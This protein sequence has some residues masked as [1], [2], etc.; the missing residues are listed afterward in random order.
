L[1][2]LWGQVKGSAHFIS[3]SQLIDY[4]TLLIKSSRCAQI[5]NFCSIIFGKEDVKGLDVAV[6]KVPGVYVVKAQSNLN[7]HLPD[8]VFC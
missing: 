2:N 3:I 8:K 5:T 1:P 4:V 6:N 7:E